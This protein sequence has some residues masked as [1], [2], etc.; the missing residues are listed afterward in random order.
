[1]NWDWLLGSLC[2]LEHLSQTASTTA[3]V[4]PAGSPEEDHRALMS[5]MIVS[6]AAT[7]S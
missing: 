1:M 2:M 6:S 7:Q 5:R 3:C 4:W